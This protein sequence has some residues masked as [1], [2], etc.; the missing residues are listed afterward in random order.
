MSA[1]TLAPRSPRLG[2]GVVW[3]VALVIA[4]V[5]GIVSPVSQRGDWLCVGLGFILILS[6]A[7]QVFGG[8]A[9]GF[10]ARISAS[11]LGALVVMG[12]VSVGF[13]LGSLF[14]I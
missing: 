9:K 14:A 3:A 4:V 6:F 13:G 7:I 8:R 5:I 10:I 1:P 11:V 2:V 12:I